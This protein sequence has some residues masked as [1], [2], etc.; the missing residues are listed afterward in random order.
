MINQWFLLMM[1]EKF[2]HNSFHGPQHF[3]IFKDMYWF[4]NNLESI[5]KC[6]DGN[7]QW[8]CAT[9]GRCMQSGHGYFERDK[10]D[11]LHFQSCPKETSP[12]K[13]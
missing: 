3:E 5:T 9:D 11:C 7:E 8:K 6:D 4:G 2:Q 12:G 1:P 10:L 13:Y